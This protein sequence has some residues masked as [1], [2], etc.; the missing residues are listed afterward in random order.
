MALSSEQ[1][2]FSLRTGGA[3]LLARDTQLAGDLCGEQCRG[4][5][6]VQQHCGSHVWD[7]ANTSQDMPC[8]TFD[9]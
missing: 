8:L 6:V 9:L 1:E 7:A 4:V 5:H 3:S 2:P